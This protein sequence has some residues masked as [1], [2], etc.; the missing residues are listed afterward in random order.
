MSLKLK[1]D[2]TVDETEVSNRTKPEIREEI[3]RINEQVDT[4][5]KHIEH[6]REHKT[7]LQTRRTDLKTVINEL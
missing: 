4:V 1:Q 2:G 5:N 3:A 6:F 7:A